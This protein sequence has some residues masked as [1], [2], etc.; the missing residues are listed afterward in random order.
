MLAVMPLTSLA[1]RSAD[2][3]PISAD[4]LPQWREHYGTVAELLDLIE[5]NLIELESPYEP[6]P[7]LPEDFIARTTTLLQ[8]LRLP[9][10]PVLIF[11]RIQGPETPFPDHHRLRQIASLR[12]LLV[13]HALANGDHAAALDLTR[14][15]LRQARASL[16]AQE[17]IIPYLHASGVWQA[18]LDAV[19]A[20]V[21][22]SGPVSEALL[23]DLLGELQ[24]D[25]TL[26]ALA[27]AQA[28]HGEYEHVYRVIVER[29]PVTDD[30]DLFL[31]SVSSLGMDDPY[32][33]EPG[34]LGLGLTNHPILDVPVTLAAYRADLAPYFLAYA[35]SSRLPRGIYAAHTVSTLA[36]Y[37][38]D[39]GLFLPYAT[40]DLVFSLANLARARVAL[41]STPN[42]GGKLL[43]VFLTPAWESILTSLARREAQRSALCALLAWRIHGGPTTWEILVAKNLL[44]AAPE[45]PFSTGALRYA[46]A[47]K[48]RVWSVFID[49]QD[50]GGELVDGNLGLPADLVWLP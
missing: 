33:L 9:A 4:A 11:D 18:A 43:A 48:P 25:S 24:A 34:E 28:L 31:S 1:V 21:R 32:P 2:E 36:A 23:R 45:D 47:P 22:D 16:R 15:N 46:L 35:R 38:E 20:I 44:P 10:S 49:E 7:A 37:R 19:H 17:G 13:R 40:G 42:P 14:Q 8:A 39:L 26:A 27:S 41:E 29:M 50:D 6:L 30:P 5:F 3:G 12:T